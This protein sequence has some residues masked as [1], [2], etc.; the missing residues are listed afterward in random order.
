[1]SDYMHMV[2]LGVTRRLLHLWVHGRLPFR[3]GALQ[4]QLLNKELEASYLPCEFQ[5]QP[6]GIK[7]LEFWKATE[8]RSFLLYLRPSLLK[9]VLTSR[10]YD[11]FLLLH[12]AIS[13]LCSPVLYLDYYD[14]ASHLLTEFSREFAKIYG[15][16]QMSYNIH[17]L[18][19]LASDAKLQGPLDSFRHS[20]LKT[21]WAS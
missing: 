17:A 6:R 18:C 13:I 1:M 4:K 19:H 21:I 20:V 14:Y 2:C 8:Y 16:S 15:K 12:C 11:H 3:L 5:R 9:R 7:E 10:L